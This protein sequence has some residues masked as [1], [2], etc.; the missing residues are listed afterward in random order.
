MK[1]P[2]RVALL[3]KAHIPSLVEIE[4]AS[5]PPASR[6]DA[7]NFR[8][9]LKGPHQTLVATVVNRVVG[10]LTYLPVDG[11][12]MIVSMAV[13]AGYRRRGVGS[14]LLGEL[15]SLAPAEGVFAHVPEPFLPAQLFFRSHRFRCVDIFEYQSEHVYYV[16]TRPL[17]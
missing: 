9:T 17:S 14:Y 13:D 15:L 2:Y 11:Q 6:W 5:F 10:Y 12:L 3:T 16:F 7:D 1:Y 4:A 8:K